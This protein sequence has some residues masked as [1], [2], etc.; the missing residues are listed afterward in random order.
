MALVSFVFALF[1]SGLP[2]VVCL[3]SVAFGVY[4]VLLGYYVGVVC[5][6]LSRCLGLEVWFTLLAFFVWFLLIVWVLW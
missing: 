2:D 3:L 5:F 6:G 1:S 4:L